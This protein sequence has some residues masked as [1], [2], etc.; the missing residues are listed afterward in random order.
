MENK[1]DIVTKLVKK[2]MEKK[3]T[4][5]FSVSMEKNWT[6]TVLK[7]YIETQIS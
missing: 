1:K 5:F 4:F 6:A 7:E 2:S 3:V